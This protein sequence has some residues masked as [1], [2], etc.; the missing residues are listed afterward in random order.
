LSTSPVVDRKIT[1]S[2]W[3]RFASVNA[4]ASS[5]AS[6]AKLCSAPSCLTAATPVGID[7]CRKAAV[8]ENTSAL[9]RGPS[10]AVA[11]A[12]A[13]MAKISSATTIAP[14]RLAGDLSIVCLL[15]PAD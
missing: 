10:S 4:A 14:S 8:F 13:G 6:T 2:Y 12:L 11:I 9:N 15:P 1:T 7:P 5:V 3:A